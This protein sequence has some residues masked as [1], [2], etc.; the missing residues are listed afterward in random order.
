MGPLLQF[1]TGSLYHHGGGPF[2]RFIILVAVVVANDAILYIQNPNDCR[3]PSVW[4]QIDV[5]P[6]GRGGRVVIIQ[7][8]IIIIIN[9][10]N[11]IWVHTINAAAAA[12]STSATGTSIV[13]DQS[14]TSVIPMKGVKGCCFVLPIAGSC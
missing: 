4:I 9:N 12:A 11:I 2:G 10:N 14:L 1:L 3:G 7:G 5:I 6:I 13:K 8:L